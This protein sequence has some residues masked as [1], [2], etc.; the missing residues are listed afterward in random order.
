MGSAEPAAP[1]GLV[2]DAR[3]A[4]HLLNRA[5]F[6]ASRRRLEAAAE[7]G[8]EAF[9]RALLESPAEDRDPFFAERLGPRDMKDE[10]MGA[11]SMDIVEQRMEGASKRGSRAADKDQLDRFRAF[12]LQRILD[13]EDPLRERMTLFWHGH[14]TSSFRDV[15]SSYE[16]VAQNELLRAN[17]LGSFADLLHGIAR[18]PAMLEYL[19]N[20]SNRKRSPN[21]NFARELLELF[22]LGE[23]NYTERDVA[24]AARAFTGWTDKNGEF[25]F[26]ENRHDR[27]KKT[28]LGATGRFD[29]D[30]VID[31]VLRQKTCGEHV[32]RRLI[33]YL[34]GIEPEPDR[35][36][37]YGAFLSEHDYSIAALLEKLFLDPRFY[38]DE[39][40]GTRVTSPID[41]IVG[42]ARRLGV[43]AP[44]RM[45][46]QASALAGQHLFEPPNVKGWEEGEAWITTSSFMARSNLVG[47]LLGVVETERSGSSLKLLA[48][49][50]GPFLNLH[51]RVRRTGAAR[52]GEIA[53]R[54]L[55]ELLAVEPSPEALAQVTAFLAAER[56]EL[57]LLD[58]A[59]LEGGPRAE[60]V[61]RRAAHLILTLPDAHLH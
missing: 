45:L 17:A 35:A 32:A 31:V 60:P 47:A 36:V 5:G 15:K 52:D 54:L 18:D 59:L 2:W 4:R 16:M 19:D 1:D 41:Y 55:V 23:G 9:V 28:F 3:A 57:G 14:F 13:D 51:H 40:V 33:T 26:A 20:D 53:E 44:G 46:A 48:R 42:C 56:E 29:G 7:M 30:D 25:Q 6:G 24:E 38:R 39:V 12:W 37:E 50:G 61:L 10:A 34:E 8:A 22:A 11:G 27:G 49:L 21:E 58:G 43:R